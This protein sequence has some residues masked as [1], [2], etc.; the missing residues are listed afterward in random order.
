MI[1]YGNG[2]TEA[3]QAG[4]VYNL[5]PT[6]TF[7]NIDTPSTSDYVFT[8][9]EL[10]DKGTLACT[11]CNGSDYPVG[12]TYCNSYEFT[13]WDDNHELLE[14]L[15]IGR[16]C[17]VT[18]TIDY[19][20]NNVV[21]TQTV[22]IGTFYVTNVKGSG[23][24]TTITTMD[25]MWW[26]D[27]HNFDWF[28]VGS[29]FSPLNV[30]G[31]ICD[32]EG[33]DVDIDEE[34]FTYI[35]ELPPGNICVKPKDLKTAEP[36][37][38]RQMLGYVCML[39]GCNAFFRGEELCIRPNNVCDDTTVCLE[40]DAN[41]QINPPEH[42]DYENVTQVSC[43]YCIESNVERQGGT[44]NYETTESEQYTITKGNNTACVVNIP[45]NVLMPTHNSVLD[46]IMRLIYRNVGHRWNTI[47]T[48]DT[49]PCWILEPGDCF[50][51]IDDF[52]EKYYSFVTEYTHDFE[53]FTTYRN[54]CPKTETSGKASMSAQATIIQQREIQASAARAELSSRDKMVVKLNNTVDTAPGMYSCDVTT[55]LG[56]T[57]HFCSDYNEEPI[58]D[59]GRY[60][61]P[62]SNIV[63]RYDA[64]GISI[65]NNGGRTY[66]YTLSSY[67]DAI[68]NNIY[69]HGID[70]DY[71]NTGTLDA[72]RIDVD[73]IFAKNVTATGTIE[74]A[75]VK[76]AKGEFTKEFTC[77]TPL[78][79]LNYQVIHAI[80]NKEME[81]GLAYYPGSVIP[82]ASTSDYTFSGLQFGER[83]VGKSSVATDCV[84]VRGAYF[85][86]QDPNNMGKYG[87]VVFA[88][89]NGNI[90]LN[91]FNDTSASSGAPTRTVT[92]YNDNNQVDIRTTTNAGLYHKAG[93]VSGGGYTQG[94]WLIYI[95]VDG[96]VHCNSTSD[97]RLKNSIKDLT[98][99]EA[100][101]IL[102]VS[103]VTFCMNGGSKDITNIGFLAQDFVEVLKEND[104][105][106]RPFLQIQDKKQGD[107]MYTDLEHDDEDVI[108]GIDYAMLTPILWKG[109]QMQQEKIDNLEE[110]IAKLEKLLETKDL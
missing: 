2:I 89:A 104:I 62:N 38:D 45:N 39:M 84:E 7:P 18:M 42:S 70:A 46:E 101:S 10:I 27:Q 6:I 52:G 16:M 22:D 49:M 53:G 74:G 30:L 33:Q 106:Y 92:V 15:T 40:F 107:I 75:T 32:E 102:S 26:F 41:T 12:Q 20:R 44:D 19:L 88:D 37:T 51:Y 66:L 105:G 50:S 99:E 63:W 1:D 95:D 55:A 77:F 23:T 100:S 96:V 90:I 85:V 58:L 25:K 48:V 94:K 68:L 28:Y 35:D 60:I 47:T 80:N 69:A 65:S 24:Q 103:P 5:R 31:I 108:Y 54:T 71:V 76:G 109:Y 87:P 43:T 11:S 8:D 21:T 83:K 57:I 81:V 97:K 4:N 67:G 34:S 59:G 86:K 82:P 64:N 13:V 36:I 79:G 61:F 73:G 110:R 9:A 56:A 17:Y 3:F 72:D 93:T 98:S 29:T 78:Q 91:G 14:E